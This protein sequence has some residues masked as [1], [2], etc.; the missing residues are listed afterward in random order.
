MMFRIIVWIFTLGLNA[1]YAD[2]VHIAVAANFTQPVKTLKTRFEQATHHQLI[3]SL[4]S[5]GQLYAQIKNGAPYEVFL[6]A[7][8]KRPQLLVEEGEAVAESLVTY[9]VGKLILWSSKPDFVDNTVLKTGDFQYLALT[10]PKTAPYGAA[11][12]QVL[13]KLGLWTS[14]QAKIVQGENITQ[15]YQFVV[16]QNAELGF[17]ALSQYQGGKHIG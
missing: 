7:D 10:N 8:T 17:V 15:T 16:T 3:I 2:T 9:A 13:E 4:G 14:L 12:V 5:T 6:A 11:A 1:V